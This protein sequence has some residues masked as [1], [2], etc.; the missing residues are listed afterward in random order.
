MSEREA[1]AA[2]DA[3]A[4]IGRTPAVWLDHL[5]DGLAGRVLLKL[6]LAN[7]GGSIKDRA[8]LRCVEDAERRGELRPGAT[9]VE[10]TSG[11][12]GIGLA[13]VCGQ[14]GYRLIAVMSEGNSPE[15]RRV[16]AAYGA[17]VELVAQAAGG[18]PG[19]VSGDDLALV[20]TRTRQLVAE[21]GAWR[22][23]QFNNP[24]NPAAHEATTGPEIWAQAGGR[25]GTIH[26]FATI[27]GT[28]GT[29]VGVARA[30][31]GRDGAIRCVAVEPAGAPVLAGGP[32][33][34]PSHKLQGA[35]YAFVPPAWEPGLCDLAVAV[36][37]EE[38]V[39]TAR[40]LARAEG[41][42]AGFSTGANVAA[43]LRLAGEVPAGA[44]IVTIACDTGLRYL[45]TDLF[46]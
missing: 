1:R 3:L 17:E 11:N 41:I 40:R 29:F 19:Q 9:V 43:A 34:N 15:R 35:G 39:A 28:G 10:L 5:T 22:P 45:S 2:P 13:I 6:E 26:A 20:E 42:V 25:A 33:T 46:G 7:P 8:A 44:T 23:D 12:M 30:L 27:V 37:D 24:S 21:L 14:K 18:A 4:L 38:A 36:T 16:L 31:K 32:V